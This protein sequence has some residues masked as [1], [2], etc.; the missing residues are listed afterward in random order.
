[1]VE[2]DVVCALRDKQAEVR[3]L[4]ERLEQQLVEHRTGL[5][6]LEGVLRLFDPSLRLEEARPGRQRGQRAWFRPGE[7]LRLIYDVLRDAAQPVATRELADRVMAM[8]NIALT[9]DRDRALIQKTL[10]ASL[11]RA[12]ETI[13]RA[14]IEGVVGW[15]VI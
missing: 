6:H 4:I 10:L 12:K 3:G 5:S 1:M 11:N 15:R 13:E 2:Q 9:D 7:S 8:K 14:T